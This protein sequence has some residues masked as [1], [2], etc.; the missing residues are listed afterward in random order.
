MP[1]TTLCPLPIGLAS[2]L[3]SDFISPKPAPMS[4]ALISGIFDGVEAGLDEGAGHLLRQRLRPLIGPHEVVADGGGDRVL[5]LGAD[6]GPVLRGVAPVDDLFGVL[7]D[8]AEPRP[9]VVVDVGGEVGDA[10]V[11]HLL[12]QR[13]LL[14]APPGPPACAA[15]GRRSGVRWRR[16]R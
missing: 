7:G 6:L 15:P 2:S 3:A 1:V 13:G 16:G 10:V 8:R 14:Q 5:Q 12:P 9:Q 11:E 4:R